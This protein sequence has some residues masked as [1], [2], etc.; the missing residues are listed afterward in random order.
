MEFPDGIYFV[1]FR[2][3][4]SLPAHVARQLRNE[5][6]EEMARALRGTERAHRDVEWQML[7]ARR[8]RIERALDTAHGQCWLRHPG[9]AGVVG[10]AL[11]RFAGER[12]ELG[13]WCIMPNHVHTLV[14]PTGTH[15]LAQILHSWKSYTA[16]T[17]NRILG[18]SG[19]FWQREYYDHLVRDIAQLERCASYILGNPS[20]AGLANWPWVS[21]G[22]LDS[23]LGI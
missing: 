21:E 13:T 7:R 2:L 3:G 6:D 20:R 17:A 19:S 18:R 1:T 23:L 14:R 8:R 10:Q 4:D 15:A 22:N 5:G 9:V 12:Y 16:K 11:K